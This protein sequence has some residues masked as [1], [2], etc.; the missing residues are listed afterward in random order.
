MFFPAHQLH[1]GIFPA[2]TGL[3]FL[4]PTHNEY[5]ISSLQLP[6]RFSRCLLL[7]TYFPRFFKSSECG[8]GS[9]G[10]YTQISS[11]LSE[12]QPHTQALPN[13]PPAYIRG[14]CCFS[15]CL[16]RSNVRHALHDWYTL[17]TEKFKLPT[18]CLLVARA[19]RSMQY[20]LRNK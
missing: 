11:N 7:A 9:I 10:S 20:A 2:N 15:S 18:N 6:Q 3:D 14:V 4:K 8:K 12:R 16:C 1:L 5:L 19:G 13:Y 17:L